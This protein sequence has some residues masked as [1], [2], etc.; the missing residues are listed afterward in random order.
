MRPSIASKPVIFFVLLLLPAV[1][2]AQDPGSVRGTVT[3]LGG[4]GL[5][6]ASVLIQGT[7]HYALTEADGSYQIDGVAP[8]DY[9]VEA[10]LEGFKTASEE[11]KVPAGGSATA[12]FTLE[13]DLLNLD[14]IVVT[15]TLNPLS[16]IESS[17]AITSKD[18]EE[19][20]EKAPLNTAQMLEVIPGFWAESS[21]GEGGNNLFARGIPQDGGFRYVAMHEDGLPIY[22][23]PELAFTNIDL[24]FRIDETV[25]VME[26][27]RGGSSSIF[28]SNAPGG[29]VNFVTRTGTDVPSTLR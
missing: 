27:V 14:A 22:E 13:L 21:G 16:K 2:A 24:L 9:V 23:S 12:D 3:D 15:G 18:A 17:V 5:P 19:I 6:G 10:I 8:G 11:V 4:D 28:A 25:E 20:R 29:I 7:A 26:A 1:A